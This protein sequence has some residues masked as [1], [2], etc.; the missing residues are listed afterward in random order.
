MAMTSPD[1]LCRLLTDT[2]LDLLALVLVEEGVRSGGGGALLW[3]TS[4][5]RALRTVASY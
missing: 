3:T 1:S 4:S 2:C 5:L